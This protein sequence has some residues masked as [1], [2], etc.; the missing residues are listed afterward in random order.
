MAR[1]SS[2]IDLQ[3]GDVIH[4]DGGGLPATGPAKVVAVS[5]RTAPD[6]RHFITTDRGTFLAAADEQH[7]VLDPGLA[8]SPWSGEGVPADAVCTAAK[9]PR[10]EVTFTEAALWCGYDPA[11]ETDAS[12]A[13]HD[14][15]V[16]D[17]IWDL[18]EAGR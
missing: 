3:P 9:A 5:R 8:A 14:H 2:T 7:H 16:W 12:A 17:R 11:C 13:R 4:V 18:A 15:R 10:P 6:G 1:R